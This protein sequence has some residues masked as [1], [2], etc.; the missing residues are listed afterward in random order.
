[1]A[2]LFGAVVFVD[3]DEDDEKRVACDAGCDAARPKTA[4]R[5]RGLDAMPRRGKSNVG[6]VAVMV[7]CLMWLLVCSSFKD[8]EEKKLLT[9]EKGVGHKSRD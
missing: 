9:R 6:S 2:G 1:M 8:D 4:L 7:W 5:R 3:D